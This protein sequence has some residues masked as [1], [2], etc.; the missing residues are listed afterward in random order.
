MEAPGPMASIS[1]RMVLT[2][3]VR[4]DANA[5]PAAFSRRSI[6]RCH[7]VS[8]SSAMRR[9]VKYRREWRI[10]ASESD[11]YTQVTCGREIGACESFAADLQLNAKQRV[12]YRRV[13]FAFAM[14]TL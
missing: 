6:E 4:D 10:Q 3:L 13:V 9:S 14:S 12:L 1:A 2:S 7:E 8:S 5:S 11:K